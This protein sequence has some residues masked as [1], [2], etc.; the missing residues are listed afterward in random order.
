MAHA[1][2]ST[3]SE[4]FF[5]SIS[6]VTFS[7]TLAFVPEVFLKKWQPPQATVTVNE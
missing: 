2:G 4:N 1:D 3:S 6:T 5:V 7:P